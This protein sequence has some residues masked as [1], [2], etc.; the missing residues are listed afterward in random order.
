MHYEIPEEFTGVFNFTNWTDKERTFL[1]NNKEYTFPAE[2]TVPLIIMGEP[3][4]NI[5]EIRKK[6]AKRLAESVFYES[7]EY[8]RMSKMG[9]GLPPTFD[10]KILETDIEKCLIPMQNA[11]ARIKTGVKDTHR[12]RATKALTDKEN[13]NYIFAEENKNIPTVGVQP[14]R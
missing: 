10:E 13:P 8:Q 12:Y 6:F 9:N 1:W 2:S 11:R 4:E 3:L 7:K 14:D 5:Q